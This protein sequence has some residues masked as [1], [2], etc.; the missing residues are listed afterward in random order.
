MFRSLW[1]KFL[2]L[3]LGVAAVALSGTFL[4]RELMLEDF[5]AYLEGEAEDRIYM[6]QADLEG[7]YQRQGAW[8]KDLQ[9]REAIRAL[10]SGFEIK[11]VDQAGRTVIDTREAIENASPLVRKRVEA[12]AQF[13]GSGSPGSFVPYHLFLSGMQIGTLEVRELRP[14]REELF[15][16]RSNRFMV[17]S[18]AIVGGIALLLSVVFSRRFTRPVKELALAA[19]AISRGDLHRRVSSSREDELGDLSQAFNNMADTLERQELLRKKLIADVAHELRTPLA[20]MQGE[21]EGMLDRLIPTDPAHLQ[22]LHDETGRLKKMV[23]GIEELNQAEAGRLALK[24]QWIE[25]K[26]FLQDIVDRYTISFQEKGTG[27]ELVCEGGRQLYADPERLSQIILNLLSNSLKATGR[28]GSVSIRVALSE[29]GLTIT[30]EDNGKGIREEEL[31]FIFERF[32]RGPGGGLGIGLTI[33]KELAEAHGAK[34]EVKSA[35][36]K[37]SAFILH[38]PG[39]A[40]HNF[41]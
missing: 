36:G 16:G 29:G 13:S 3:F 7:A 26:P 4:L 27:L 8:N 10:M 12:F 32:Y 31:P 17:L 40:V 15:L 2:F 28:G 9:G 38:F 24:K 1:L 41:S 14:R 18:M 25:I 34:V 23:S 33:V 19:S 22:S 39:E 6:I 21:L 5:R 11:L 20:V 35:P 37:G 30:V